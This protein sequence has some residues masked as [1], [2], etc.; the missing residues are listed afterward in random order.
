MAVLARWGSP[1]TS[2]RERTVAINRLVVSSSEA[3]LGSVKRRPLGNLKSQI[4][5]SL[6]SS[7]KRFVGANTQRASSHLESFKNQS[8]F[9][10]SIAGAA[11]TVGSIVIAV[12]I[13]APATG[14]VTPLRELR[15]RSPARRI[16][17]GRL[18][19]GCVAAAHKSLPIERGARRH[20]PLSSGPSLAGVLRRRRARS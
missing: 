5:L 15:P 16:E 3:W 7:S 19:R 1:V 12:V 18:L 14:V 8:R 11:A 9:E 13:E 17:S 2:E 4:I 6:A 10:P 20:R